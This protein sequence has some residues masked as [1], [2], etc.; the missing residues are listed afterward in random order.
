MPSLAFLVP[1]EEVP[2]LRTYDGKK[3]LT[4]VGRQWRVSVV[5]LD[6]GDMYQAYT[7]VTEDALESVLLRLDM[8]GIRPAIF[9]SE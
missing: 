8:V 5:K 9:E 7:C 3:E 4:Y 6:V 2:N 1:Q